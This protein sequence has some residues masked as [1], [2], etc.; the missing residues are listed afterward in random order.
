MKFKSSSFSPL[1]WT[2]FHALFLEK[3]VAKTLRNRKKDEF[4]ALEQG[5][6]FVDSYE[7]KFHPLSRCATQIVTTQEDMIRLFI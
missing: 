4:M 3:Y 7:A 6:M 5:G 2:Y 1:T